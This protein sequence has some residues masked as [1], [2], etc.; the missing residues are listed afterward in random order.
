MIDYEPADASR[1]LTFRTL[2]EARRYTHRSGVPPLIV[3][4]MVWIVVTA[5][6]FSVWIADITP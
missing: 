1:R 6:G 3:Q 2:G 4:G 5:R